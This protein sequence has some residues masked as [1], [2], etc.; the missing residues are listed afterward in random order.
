MA[1]N[2]P[3]GTGRAQNAGPP[4]MVPHT[5]TLRKPAKVTPLSRLKRGFDSRR[6]RQP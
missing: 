5:K 1:L 3:W 4:R 6:G 2:I